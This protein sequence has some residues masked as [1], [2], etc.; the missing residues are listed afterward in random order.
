M[1]AA[2]L[3]QHIGVRIPGGKQFFQ[4]SVVGIRAPHSFRDAEIPGS[5]NGI[6]E[7]KKSAEWR[8]LISDKNREWTD[9]PNQQK[10][11]TQPDYDFVHITSMRK[12][13]TR[14]FFFYAD[15]QSLAFYLIE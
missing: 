6:I 14:L 3:D 8:N 10:S 4:L 2:L 15:S 12:T 13:R 1:E 11:Q 7:S 9:S 5:L